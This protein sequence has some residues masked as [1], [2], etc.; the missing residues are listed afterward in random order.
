LTGCVPKVLQRTGTTIK[1]G[2][3]EPSVWV[4]QLPFCD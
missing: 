1:I 4:G 3:E 2:R